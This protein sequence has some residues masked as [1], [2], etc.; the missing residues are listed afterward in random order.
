MAVRIDKNLCTGLHRAHR[1]QVEETMEILA[2]GPEEFYRS[3][4]NR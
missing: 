1:R 4:Q 2:E 3:Y